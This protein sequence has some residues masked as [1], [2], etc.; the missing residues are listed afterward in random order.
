[1][2][3]RKRARRDSTRYPPRSLLTLIA[4]VAVACTET[5]PA[6]DDVSGTYVGNA[7]IRPAAPHAAAPDTVSTPDTAT[8]TL[9]IR[10][11]DGFTSGVWTIAGDTAQPTDPWDAVITG[12]YTAGRMVLEYHS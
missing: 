11:S 4:V 10:E 5:A 6:P 7:A 1:M 2:T 8:Y 9:R 3:N 12:D